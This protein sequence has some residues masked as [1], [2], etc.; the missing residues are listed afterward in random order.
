MELHI[1][2]LEKLQTHTPVKPTYL[3]AA[4]STREENYSGPSSLAALLNEATQHP[5]YI[6]KNIVGIDDVWVQQLPSGNHLFTLD[7]RKANIPQWKNQSGSFIP[8]GSKLFDEETAKRILLHFRD[9]YQT[10]DSIVINCVQGKNRSPALAIGLNE[11]YS[12]GQ[13]KDY[14][15]AKYAEANWYIYKIL[16]ETASKYPDLIR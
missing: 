4:I 16:I 6:H 11:I 12:L 3:L 14:L 9:H 1:L 13:D 8:Q 2:S 15:N 7:E 5:K 10:A